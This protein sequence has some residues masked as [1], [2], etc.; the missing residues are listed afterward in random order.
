MSAQPQPEPQV[1]GKFMG[2]FLL[3][4]LL[5]FVLYV[6]P[7][8]LIF[9][10]HGFAPQDT[11][12]NA[13]TDTSLRGILASLWQERARVLNPFNNPLVRFFLVTIVVGVVYDKMKK[14]LPS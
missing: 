7:E 12:L 1:S 9:K 14:Y 4:V 10:Q 5:V 13:G 2:W 11:L 8:F 6:F 3:F